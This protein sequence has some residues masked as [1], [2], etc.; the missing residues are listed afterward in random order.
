M[1]SPNGTI[2]KN[3]LPQGDGANFTLSR[4]L[5]VPLLVVLLW[6]ASWLGYLIAF[7][8]FCIAGATDYLVRLVAPDLKA[9]ARILNEVFLPHPSVAHV[10]SSI[11]LDQLKQTT[12]LP[13]RHLQP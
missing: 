10:R 9:L 1:F 5:A 4:I 11:V 7:V 3:W 2:K 13:L 12:Q 6:N 8:V